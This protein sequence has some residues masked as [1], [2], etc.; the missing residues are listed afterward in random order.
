MQPLLPSKH[1]LTGTTPIPSR[2]SSTRSTTSR[3]RF[4]SHK[5]AGWCGTVATSCRGTWLTSLLTPNSTSGAALTPVVPE[6][7]LR[8]SRHVKSVQDREHEL[9][10]LALAISTPFALDREPGRHVRR[11][12][13]VG[14][15]GISVRDILY[16]RSSAAVGTPNR[17]SAHRTALG[18]TESA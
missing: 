1:G 14:R 16:L 8:P 7:S 9:P 3:A 4:Q 2:P 15:R 13:L 10:V 12:D 11:A 5:R 17:A 18:S 6:Q